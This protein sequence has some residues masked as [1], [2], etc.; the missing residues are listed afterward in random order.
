MSV[1][2]STVT[3]ATSNRS[4]LTA[5]TGDLITVLICGVPQIG[6]WRPVAL[7]FQRRMVRAEYRSAVSCTYWAAPDEPDRYV[8]TLRTLS[9]PIRCAKV[10]LS[11]CWS[12]SRM[13]RSARR[14]TA[15]FVRI[16]IRVARSRAV[17]NARL[18]SFADVRSR[19]RTLWRASARSSSTNHWRRSRLAVIS[20]VR[21]YSD[22]LPRHRSARPEPA[23]RTPRTPA[24]TA[25]IIRR[26]VARPAPLSVP[27]SARPGHRS[28]RSRPQV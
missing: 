17:M 16:P 11:G 20:A 28:P 10:Y 12:R 13:S 21:A 27:W 18:S 19:C 2:R 5:Q 4:P 25:V 15:T 3:I 24:Q 9:R 7:C 26:P 1:G 14:Y 22:R 6:V 8:R 23:S